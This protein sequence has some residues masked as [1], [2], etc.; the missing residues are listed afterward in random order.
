MSTISQTVRGWF[1]KGDDGDNAPV[2]MPPTLGVDT[3][4]FG[5]G[6]SSAINTKLL[7]LDQQLLWVTVT[8]MVFGLIMVYSASIALPDNP[9]FAKYSHTYFSLAATNDF[10]ITMGS[11]EVTTQSV[12]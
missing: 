4:H 12:F 10:A 8:L 7:G 9:R 5:G 6:N 3:S 11:N 2:R 1:G